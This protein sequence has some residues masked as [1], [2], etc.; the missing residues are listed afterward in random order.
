MPLKGSLIRS[1]F[2]VLAC[3]A[4]GSAADAATVNFSATLDLS[5]PGVLSSSGIN[6]LGTGFSGLSPQSV[7]VF[8]DVTIKYTFGGAGV[9]ASDV[10]FGWAYII[11]TGGPDE[12]AFLTGQFSLLDQDGNVIAS[13]INAAS[14]EQP[15][16]IGQQWFIS[17]GPITFYGAQWVGHVDAAVP[18][19][20]RLYDVP[21]LV[22][23]G[24]NF[25]GVTAA[26]PEPST[27]A[28]MILGF[29]GI[30]FM[31]YRRRTKKLAT[32]PVACF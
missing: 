19:T 2:S 17:T 25:E 29:A 12:Q 8:D 6:A 10:G 26:V 13:S 20:T 5:T 31:S 3:A 23:T 28:M 18:S 30:G 7:S 32:A 15:T 4:V 1:I 14:V 27:W 11:S 9:S 21:A 22:I 24:E 16:N